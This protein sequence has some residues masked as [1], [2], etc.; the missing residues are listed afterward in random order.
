MVR[1]VCLFAALSI[2]V[3][4]S[5]IWAQSQP[6][7]VVTIGCLERA[8]NAYVLKDFRD[9]TAFQINA[10][11]QVAAPAENLDWHIG[12]ELEVHGT[13]EGTAQGALRLRATQIVYV[14]RTCP[15]GSGA[16]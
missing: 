11:P 9:G 4:A 5:A 12:H 7:E 15:F 8:G 6:H 10:S 2:V 16:R 13:L 3:S 1:N 14:S